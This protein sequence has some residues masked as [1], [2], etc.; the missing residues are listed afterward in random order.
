MTL[1][2]GADGTEL[3]FDEI[4]PADADPVIVLAGGPARHPAYLGGLAG[5]GGSNR[6]ILPH[7]RGVGKSPAAPDPGRA[8]WVGQAE[9]I[10]LLDQALGGG[11][12]LVLAHSAGARVAIRYLQQNPARVKG[13][14]LI[15]PAVDWLVHA[16][17][18]GP[19]IAARRMKEEAFRD[20][21]RIVTGP[22]TYRD[23]PTFNQWQRA[24]APA[25]YAHWGETEQT[26]SRVGECRLEA[27]LAYLE[28]GTPGDLLD[29]IS[30]VEVPV[31]SIA[32]AEDALVGCSPV[33]ALSDVFARGEFVT[34]DDCGHYP[35]VEQ[36]A[37][38]VSVISGFTDSLLFWSPDEK[39]GEEQ[40]RGLF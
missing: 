18:D 36:P 33:R 24:I 3:W 15:T 32:G 8:T 9:D 20:A 11:P 10:V 19:E 39:P 14:A 22:R 2:Q 13:L 1:Y 28:A 16:T 21:W 26:H 7:L 40:E 31:L 38:F 35:W 23:E 30:Q 37:A 6:L 27:A 34:I 5:L 29:R 12:K 17:P 25:G 4:G